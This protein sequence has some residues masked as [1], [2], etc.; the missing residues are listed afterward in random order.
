MDT[1]IDHYLGCI[2]SRRGETRQWCGTDTAANYKK[3][4]PRWTNQ[5]SPEDFSYS[6]NSAGF[7][8]DEFSEESELPVLFNGCSVTEGIGVPVTSTWSYQLVEKLRAATGKKIPYWNI[9]FG[10]G[11]FDTMAATS[12]WFAKNVKVKPVLVFSLFPSMHR[13]DYC[14]GKANGQLWTPNSS[15]ADVDKLFTDAHFAQHQ[16]VRSLN[17]MEAL[18]MHWE[19]DAYHAAWE[20]QASEL[21]RSTGNN[22]VR[23]PVENF[24]R[25]H[26]R[27][28]IHPGVG[29]HTSMCSEYWKAVAPKL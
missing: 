12:M 18:Y 19:C 23:Y 20:P 15:C 8:C 4:H 27:D 1:I 6:F 29:S 16:C 11:G 28:G 21:I 2:N 13:R 14:F 22:F 26:A 5:F 7:R 3:Q 25:P 17:I 10:G 24:R 9:A